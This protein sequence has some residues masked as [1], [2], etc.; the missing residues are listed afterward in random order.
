MMQHLCWCFHLLCLI[1]PLLW[2]VIDFFNC[3]IGPVTGR[4]N[5][6]LCASFGHSGVPMVTQHKVSADSMWGSSSDVKS[7]SA[8]NQTAA[9]GIDAVAKLNYIFSAFNRKDSTVPFLFESVVWS[10][11]LYGLWRSYRCCLAYLPHRAGDLKVL[12]AGMKW[13]GNH[14]DP[15]LWW[16]VSVRLGS[17]YFSS[18][19]L[20]RIHYYRFMM[21][22]QNSQRSSTELQLE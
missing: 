7:L 10:I 13:R 5:L 8:N 19:C 1:R 11:S 4:D 6:H 18:S 14:T 12:C 9:G 2:T 21:R 20:E 22:S 3:L 17:L 15:A 16:F